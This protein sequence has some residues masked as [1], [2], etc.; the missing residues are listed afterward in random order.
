MTDIAT[1]FGPKQGKDDAFDALVGVMGLIRIADGKRPEHLPIDPVITERE[2]W[3]V[4]MD[5]C[6][7][8]RQTKYRIK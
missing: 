3:I 5:A 6:T 8:K 1:G 2:G 4:G 7:I